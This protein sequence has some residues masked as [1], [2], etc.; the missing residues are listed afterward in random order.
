LV[1][2]LLVTLAQSHGFNLLARHAFRHKFTAFSDLTIA[3]PPVPS[4]LPDANR[5]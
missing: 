4:P 3:F 1:N 5:R 2:E